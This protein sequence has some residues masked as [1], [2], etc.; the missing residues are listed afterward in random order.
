MAGRRRRWGPNPKGRRPGRT[1]EGKTLKVAVS[2][3]G[4]PV[5]PFEPR[6]TGRSL[7]PE[8]RTTHG[9]P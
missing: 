5:Q 7:L 1:L 8:D 6:R 2:P 9:G 3:F 4:R